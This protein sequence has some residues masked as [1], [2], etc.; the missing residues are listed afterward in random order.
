M[1]FYEFRRYIYGSLHKHSCSINTC[2]Y[3]FKTIQLLQVRVMG[4]LEVGR[5]YWGAR[6]EI[7]GSLTWPHG[8]LTLWK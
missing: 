7:L 3:F 2:K 4:T 6:R 5:W 1:C 8:Y